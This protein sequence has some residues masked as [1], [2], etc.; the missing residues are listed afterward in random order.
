MAKAPVLK[1]FSNE[2][3]VTLSCDASQYGLGCVILQNDH[4]VS[5]ASKALSN[6]EQAYAQIEK[7]LLAIVFGCSRFHHL[8]YGRKFTIETD[9]LPLVRIVEKPLGQVPLRLQ[10]MLL[11]LQNYDFKLVGKSGKDIPL[12]DGL[13]RAP[14]EDSN[15]LLD[16]LAAFSV[17]S[18][19]VSSLA[20]FSPLKKQQLLKH[21]E[22]D[23]VYQ[24]LIRTIIQGWPSCRTNLDDQLKPFWDCRE[25]LSVYDGIVFR[26]ER[27]VIP[28][29]MQSEILQILH[30]SHQGMVRTK[31]LAR[32]VLYWCGINK[33]IEDMVSKCATCQSKKPQQQREPMISFPVPS[34][35]WEF[36]STDLF[37]LDGKMYLL[38]VDHY[39]GFFEV[40]YLSQN[41]RASEVVTKM[42]AVFARHGIPKVVYSDN[43]PQYTSHEFK[44][45]AENYQ[46]D[47]KTVSARYPQSNGL[48]EKNVQIA[49]N[50]FKKAMETHD[51][52]YLAL[53]NLRNTPRNPVL[54]SPA[55]RCMG[56]RTRTKL[57]V[58]DALL[59]PEIQSPSNVQKALQ[60]SRETS[61]VYYDRQVKALPPLHQGDTI[62][63]RDDRQWVPAQF[64]SAADKPRSYRVRTTAG[65]IVTRNR[66]HLLRTR[67]TD[68]Y[69]QV[70]LRNL[71]EEDELDQNAVPY[72]PQPVQ[73][74]PEIPNRPPIAPT[75]PL[76]TAARP[77]QAVDSQPV[78]DSSAT[79]R[80]GRQTMPPKWMKDYVK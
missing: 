63:I 16:D 59:Q 56:R 58:S 28:T 7:E 13:S 17:C 10:K 20:A 4:P 1:Y 36:A 47:H 52:I 69:D 71:L 9:H 19:E 39:S 73:H 70:R 14:I 67:E 15:Q 75:R 50:V 24:K 80:S 11:K 33:Q 25:E 42:K 76:E 29:G 38:T 23:P 51:D 62:R 40:D 57:P 22:D 21:A 5:Y 18:A 66:K 3:P 43:G 41:S 6:A 34:L 37:E 60:V 27:I 72:V 32:D 64:V 12:A 8:L 31:Q 78:V 65:N 61:K 68:S 46:F 79:T 74:G 2:D 55:Q 30:A 77:S 44:E 53:L 48:A 35:P 26:G 49:K 54:G 45:F